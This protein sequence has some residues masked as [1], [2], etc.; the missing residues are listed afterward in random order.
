MYYYQ[1]IFFCIHPNTCQV[2]V[3]VERAHTQ[4]TVCIQAHLT[5]GRK[6]AVSVLVR[7]DKWL[8]SLNLS[9]KY[10]CW[11]TATGCFHTENS[12][13][14]DHVSCKGNQQGN[15]NKEHLALYTN[16]AT[17]LYFAGI[18]HVL[19]AFIMNFTGWMSED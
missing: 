1:S 5:A 13:T 11:K 9:M 10:H 6:R 15:K 19:S 14:I 7:L 16:Q 3:A 18:K 17:E 12:F 4:N 8:F 2:G